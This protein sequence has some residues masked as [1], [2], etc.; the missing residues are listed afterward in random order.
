[1]PELDRILFASDTV[2]VGAFRC[3]VDDPRFADSGPIHDSLIAFPRRGVWIRQAGSRS[4]V[5]DPALATIYNRHRRYDRRP[6]SAEGDASDWYAVAPDVAVALAREVDPG[7][8]DEPERAFRFEAAPVDHGCYL[9]QRRLFLAIARGR[10]EPL[11]I[12]EQVL[13]LM[14]AVLRRAAGT[15]GGAGRPLSAARRDL[16][17]RAKAELAR[18]IAEPTDLRRLSAA[19]G[20]SPSHLCRVFLAGTGMRLHQY[21]IELRLRAALEGL[22]ETAIGLSPLAAALGFSSHSHFT[23]VLRRTHGL[24]PSR[25]RVLLGREGEPG[26][27][28][29]QAPKRKEDWS[30]EV[31]ALE[32][33]SCPTDRGR[34]TRRSGSASG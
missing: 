25:T 20:T 6:I 18:D 2:R 11:A 8:P 15:A 16:V 19:L 32:G 23:A 13:A 9:R 17:E 1:M 7:A 21:R 28:R 3:P 24:T 31:T 14:A 33:Y 4:M 26:G 34:G 22:G 12:E 5:A 29:R 27:G 30:R 10:L